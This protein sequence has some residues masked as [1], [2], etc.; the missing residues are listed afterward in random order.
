MRMPFT[1]GHSRAV[2]SLAGAAAK[3]LG[4]PASD[5][6][7]VRWAAYAHDIGELAVPVS[8]W[9]RAGALTER[10]TD[11]ARLHPYH[12]ERALTSLGGD[13]KQV[14]SLVQRHHEH[15]DGSGY[16]RNSRGPDLS[17]AARILA[18]AEAFQTAR[19]ARPHRPAAT[20]AAAAAKLRGAV[21][22]GQLC[23]DAVEAVLTCVGQR[24]RRTAPKRLAGLTP[25]EI[26]VL[27][28]I[29]AGATAKEAA[30]KL[31]IATKTADNHI[32]SLYSKIGVTTRAGA[33]LYALERGLIQHE[34]ALA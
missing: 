26:E 25:R 11:G 6:R 34:I 18:A 24:A 28:L 12:G 31:D 32:Q 8:T 16:H 14:A 7:N 15:L 33:A 27:R 21:K 19:E 4:L 5:I 17:P 1:F 20:D 9:M 22:E 10:E 13:G 23:P 2:A 30:S 3:Q 29:A